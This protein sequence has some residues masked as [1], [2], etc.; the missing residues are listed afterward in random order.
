M[1]PIERACRDVTV[2]GSTW[3]HTRSGTREAGMLRKALLGPMIKEERE[4]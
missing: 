4:G 1:F 3:S 2:K